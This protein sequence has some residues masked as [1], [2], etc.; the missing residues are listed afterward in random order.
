MAIVYP[1]IIIALLAIIIFSFYKHRS[2]KSARSLPGRHKKR[3]WRRQ[4]AL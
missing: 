1:V 3:R 2:I 4:A